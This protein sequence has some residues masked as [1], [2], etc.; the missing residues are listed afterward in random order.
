MKKILLVA[1]LFSMALTSCEK[2][3][4]SENIYGKDLDSFYANPTEIEEALG[5]IYTSMYGVD[6]GGDEAMMAN[7]IDDITLGGGGAGGEE[8]ST[9]ADA[10]RNR[11][12]DFYREMWTDTYEGVYRANGIIERLTASDFNIDSFFDSE[13]EADAYTS[14]VLG[15]AYFMRGLLMFRAARFFGGMP[16]IPKTDSARDVPRSSYTETFQSIISDFKVAID[17]LPTTAANRI[18]SSQYGHANRWIAMGYIARAYMFY[19]GYM[20]N[21]ESTPTTTITLSAL[22]GGGELTKE[23]VIDYL[24]SCIED[25]GYDLVTRYANLW[26]YSHLNY[27][28]DNNGDPN[29]DNLFPWAKTEGLRWAGQDGFQA[30]LAG[31]TG[32][33]EVMFSVRYGI[34]EFNTP[35]NVGISD[36]NRMCIAS[37]PRDNRYAPFFQG[38][39]FF[40]VHPQF[41]ADW[42]DDD[43]RK[44]AT[45][46]AIGDASHRTEGYV[47]PSS[48]QFTG[49]MQKKYTGMHINGSRGTMSQFC[50]VYNIVSV[51]NAVQLGHAIDFTL[52]RYSDIL[53]MQSELTETADMMNK[54]RRRA[55]LTDIAYSLDALKKERMYE[56]A[57]EAMRWYDLVRWGDVNNTANNYYSV[58]IDVQNNKV[59]EPYSVSYPAEQKGLLP[60]P[61][62]EISLSNGAY[63]QNPGWGI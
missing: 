5:A 60:V 47:T 46:Y 22:A 37:G 56:F 18:P 15:E 3:L 36:T 1:V 8:D 25:S 41:Y 63:T 49:L 6:Y 61:E 55:G 62:T 20:T 39:G 48:H 7:A 50:Y 29:G 54:V 16:I 21:I 38:W 27:V 32:N 24:N 58:E 10:F 14:Q 51:D 33:P 9:Y 34:G 57:Y 28:A 53:L 17:Y 59:V 4:D 52:M 42:S 13:A 26:A 23:M 45:V 2:F 44:A 12:V 31:T 40:S 43:E 35:S 11:G 19:T 30:V